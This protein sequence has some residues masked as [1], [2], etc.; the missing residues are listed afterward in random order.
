MGSCETVTS[1]NNLIKY[2]KNKNRFTI[3]ALRKLL[4]PLL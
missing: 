1:T 2:I 4:T 3:N